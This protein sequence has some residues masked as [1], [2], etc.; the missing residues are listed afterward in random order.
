MSTV[1]TRDEG[2]FLCGQMC[3]ILHRLL[4]RIVAR[5]C[6]PVEWDWYA[7]RCFDFAFGELLSIPEFMQKIEFRA[8]ALKVARAK[9]DVERGKKAKSE[10]V[11]KTVMGE[12]F[13]PFID[14]GRQYLKY[15]A[16]EMLRHPKFK[17]DLV[18]GLECFDYAML[19][20]LPKTCC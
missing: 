12:S 9:I 18:I 5:S 16:K 13:N 4:R 20:K 3:D 2:F 7:L 14:Q 11:A 19:F 8:K 17:S 10:A 15:V 1:P 6:L